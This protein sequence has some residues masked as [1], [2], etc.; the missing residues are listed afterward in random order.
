MRSLSFTRSSPAPV[1]RV[2][3]LGA[4]GQTREPAAARR[5]SRDLVAADVG[6][7]QRARGHAERG[8]GLP[9]HARSPRQ[10]R[11]APPSGATVGGTRCAS[12]S[13]R[14]RAGA[15][16]RCPP[17]PRGRR[18]TR[19]TT[20]RRHVDVGGA[21]RGHGF[22]RHRRGRPYG[23]G[24][25][26]RRASAR[27]GRAR[28]AVRAPTRAPRPR[29]RRAGRRSSPARWPP[30]CTSRR[31]AAIAPYTII[32]RPSPRSQ[33]TRAPIAS[34]GRTMRRIGRRL[35]LSSPTKRRGERTAPR[36]RRP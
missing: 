26:A 24:R 3:A 20:D 10:T 17:S 27:C 21:K 4:R 23:P 19:P 33:C 14:R 7:A 22:Q 8:H 12:D 31:R 25:R 30:R 29:A 32:G 1:M 2:V 11:R 18:R 9:A 35:R 5:S 28:R 36:P 16:R 13:R 15:A 34:S 6:S